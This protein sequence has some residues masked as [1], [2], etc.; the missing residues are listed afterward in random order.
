MK[1]LLTILTLQLPLIVSA[2]KLHS[3]FTNNATDGKG[4]PLTWPWSY[5]GLPWKERWWDLDQI[6]EGQ[7]APNHGQLAGVLHKLINN[8]VVGRG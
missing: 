6:L 8:K 7:S 4:E 2:L 3:E 1:I 5:P